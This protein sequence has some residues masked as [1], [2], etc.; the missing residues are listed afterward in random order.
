MDQEKSTNG[1][2][3]AGWARGNAKWLIIIG[4]LL[5]VI[6]VGLGYIMDTAR[7]RIPVTVESFMPRGEVTR[8]TN[9]TIEFSQDMAAESA[10]GVQ[11]DSAPVVFSPAIPGKYRWIARNKLRFFPEMILLPSTQYTAEILPEICTDENAYLK[12]DRKYSFYTQRF[13]VDNVNFRFNLAEPGT[14]KVTASA[15][16]EFNYPVEPDEARKYLA[17]SYENG[18]NI[19]YRII[20]EKSGLIMELETDPVTRGEDDERMQLRIGSGLIPVGGTLGLHQDYVK[21]FIMRAKEELKVEGVFVEQQGQTGYLKIRFS[22]PVAAETAKRYIAVDPDVDYQ[23]SASHNYIELRG[24]FEAGKAYTVTINQDLIGEDGS[25]LRTN[26]SGKA[27]MKNLEP[28][29]G[30]V[31]DGIYLSRTGNLNIGLATVNIDKVDIEVEKVY[32]NNLIHLVNTGAVGNDRGWYNL[33]N[34]GKRIHQEE[35]VIA[36]RP[37]EEVITPINMK[38]Y[39]T[40]ERTGVFS[41]VVRDVNRRWRYS[42]RW[43]MITDL[44]IMVKKAGDQF[45]VWVNS[46]SSL[47][48]VAG[49]QV[50]LFSRNNQVMMEGYTDSDG[51]AQFTL[52]KAISEEFSPFLVTVEHKEDMSFLELNRRQVSTTDFDVTGQPYLRHGYDA[53]V[54]GERDIYRPGEKANLVALVRGPNN[55]VPPPFPLKM[56]ILGPDNRIYDEFRKKINEEGA[57]EFQVDLPPY[58]KTGRYTARAIVGKDYE[59][60]RGQFSVEEFMPDR[61]KVKLSSD[62]ESYDLGQDISINVEAV[63][64]FGPPAAGRSVEA[65]SKIASRRFNAPKWR[66]FTFFDSGRQFREISGNLGRA[67]LDE[68]G[69]H[70]FVLKTQKGMTPPSALSG[71]FTV[72]VMEPGGRAVTGYKSVDINPYSH[73]VG[74]RRVKE[75]YEDINQPVEMEFVAVDQKGE[76]APGR[77]CEVSF[78]RISWQSILKRVGG[79]RGY[80]YVSEKQENLEKSFKV[81]SE[82]RPGTFTFTPEQY[83]EYRITIRDLESNS[84]ASTSFYAS[85]W[86]YAPWAMDSPERLEI[87]LDKSSYRSGET[88]KVQI[89]APFAGK[90]LLTVEGDKI[91]HHEALMMDENTATVDIKALPEYKPNVYISASVIRSTLSLER[92]AP[93]RAFGVVP[94]PIDCSD[95]KLN[96]TLDAPAEMRPMK[97]LTVSFTVKPNSRSSASGVQHLTIAAVDE[98]ICQLTNFQTPDP[99]AHFFGKKRLG[100]NSYDIYSAVLPEIENATARSS[101][102]GDAEAQRRKRISPISVM[103]VKP[104]AMWSGLVKT[105]RNGRGSVKFDIP[106][107]NGT[108][109]IM[110]VS[111]SGGNFGSARKDIKVFDP[112]V[113]TPTFP[114]FM[115]GGDS[116]MAPVSIFNGTG[117]ADKFTVKLN[118]DGPAE[119]GDGSVLSR[120]VS[121]NP[122]EEGQ[123][124][125]P[126]KAKKRMGKVTFA[127]SA[128]G[129]GEAVSITTEVPLRPAAPA[130]TLSGSGTIKAGAEASFVFPGDWVQDTTEFKLTLSS[131]PA[132]Q[133][134]G[135]LQY[136]L[137]Y[138]YGCA[139]QTASR[140]F[141][142]LYFN[143]MAKVAEPELFGTQSVDYFIEEGITR[144]MNMMTPDGDFSFW[145]GSRYSNPWTSIYVSHF[146]VEARKAGYDIPDRVYNNMIKALKSHAKKSISD[147]WEL[148][149]KTYACYV[150]AMAGR[151]EKSV[152]LYLKNNE[153]NRMSDY[154]QFQ[155]AGAFALSG[156]I[157]AARSLFPATV[158]PQEVMR[159]SGRNFNSSVRAKAIMLNSLAEVDPDHP[160]VPK[161]IKSLADE[162]ARANRWY[163]T[164]DNA[165]AFLALGKIMQKRPPGKYTGVVKIDGAEF[166]SF[167]SGDRQFKNKGWGGKTITLSVQGTGNC[168]YYWTAFGIPATP[169]VKEY[170]RE[171]KVRRRYLSREGKAI[172]YD[173]IRQGDMI[174]AEITAR[175]LTEN[176]DNVVISDLLPAGFE[177]ENPRLESRAGIPWIQGGSRADYMDIR[178]DRMLLFTNLRRQK[179]KKFYYALRAV[180]VGEFVLP[181]VAAEAMYDPAKSSAANS[182]SV[183]VVQ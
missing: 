152:M 118:I 175:A 90:L 39:L 147:V 36:N 164:Q 161:L 66:S 27:F 162:A 133:F 134:A 45:L 30:F 80:Q 126:L 142:L 74:L 122:K 109:R 62:S 18:R 117:K 156:D 137:R 107:F 131:F 59:I 58:I 23:L 85:G 49:S 120:E 181:P 128:S 182:G 69:K 86:G 100:V 25:K 130:I 143:D 63:N 140:L 110:A 97:P 3:N 5:A 19:P 41:A 87:D 155:L 82:A 55:T 68:Q 79:R 6:A 176:L 141:P 4:I 48:P 40:D 121:L 28:S 127:L 35:L 129:G 167:Q 138:P 54:Y 57:C 76:I 26:F 159:E 111:F 146:M 8:T 61:I 56:E 65:R 98:G 157:N 173:Q 179:D 15:T 33:S 108:L 1:E 20:T 32:V 154:S 180:T 104:V 2:K 24:N 72:T 136:L 101:A 53:F 16:V 148:Q 42:R 112:I 123:I 64:L 103:R 88:V 171:L 105:D 21:A 94:L 145:P 7:G 78:Y 114:R 11:R 166:G 135:S 44:G 38:S 13:R 153:L 149:T 113:L 71:I 106:Q 67:T 22:S 132:M 172:K 17:V 183:K 10:V 170:D 29:V 12:G 163:T 51:L 70:K 169:D 73:Y 9:F 81:T 52:P 89:R 151:P 125:F 83:G 50:T 168:Y 34:L 37:N 124:V 165:F 178:D 46:L 158:T 174:I 115:A 31:G 119:S 177:I 75:G 144:L 91:Y 43:M 99:F 84:S 102:S 92:H 139:E 116:F 60:G 93:V 96:I 14:A 47:E 77:E 160:S 95:N 150:L